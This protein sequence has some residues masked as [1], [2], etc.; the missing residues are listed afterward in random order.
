MEF[1]I[2]FQSAL[3]Y[4]K[5]IKKEKNMRTIK[6]I[7]SSMLAL[8]MLVGVFAPY[9]AFAEDE[10]TSKEANAVTKTVTLHKLVMTKEELA[11]WDSDKVEKS[12]Y[13]GTQNFDAL[14]AL[15]ELKGKNIKEVAGV[16]FAFKYKDGENKG[17]YVTI[18]KTPA[19][20]AT[21]SDYGAADSLNYSNSEY[22]LLAGLTTSTGIQFNTAGLKGK[23]EI[24]E[25]HDKSTYTGP[26]GETITSS[27][28]VPVEITLPLVNNNGTV[29]NAHVY[30]KNTEDKPKIDKDFAEKANPENPRQDKDNPVEHQIG[31]TIPYEIKTVIPA[32]SKYA[33]AVWDDKMTEGLTLNKEASNFTVKVAGAVL[34]NTTDYTLNANERGFILSLTQSGLDKINNKDANVMVEISYSAKLNQYAVVE[35]PESNDVMFHY[36]NNPGFG[37]T[38]VPNKPN[39]GNITVTKVMSGVEWPAEGI[40]V[41]LV[42]ANT[43]KNVGEPVTLT[44]GASSYTWNNLDNETEYKV[45][46]L[47]PGYLVTYGKGNTAGTLT[48]E[49]KNNPGNP[50]PLNPD[51]PKVVTYG[52]KFVKTNQ[53]GDLRLSGA[54]FVIKNSEGKY[55][56]AKS[57]ETLASDAQAVTKAKADLDSAITTYNSLTEEQQKKPNENPAKDALALINTTQEAYNKAVLEAGNTYVWADSKEKAM[58]LISDAEGR[59]EIKGLKSGEYTL[60][61]IKAPKGYAKIDGVSFIVN[62]TSYSAEDEIKYNPTDSAN[63]AKQIVNKKVTIP[64]TGGIGTIIFTVAGLALM[65]GAAYAIKKNRE[66]A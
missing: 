12:G 51:E 11:A 3:C 52:K 47:T 30:P 26:A 54:E 29:L 46:E 5:K 27:K 44:S 24:V 55:L 1:Y 42:N 23:F 39:E 25:V 45:V 17:K 2:L 40:K 66:E 48:I 58:T 21:T 22:E 41:Q 19:S 36:G 59:F 50:T 8:A 37:N 15:Q 62:S 56:Q 60:E 4:A 64:Q 57:G 16:Y 20:P 61:E 65:L 34:T 18:K 53:A 31:D 28:A 7:L 9:T 13:D 33:T 14:K 38:P 49:N 6:K 10:L 35:V 32:N 43:G 63:T